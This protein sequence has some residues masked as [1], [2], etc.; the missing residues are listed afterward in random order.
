MSDKPSSV[1]ADGVFEPFNVEQMPFEQYSRGA[2]VGVRFQSFG[3]SGRV[4]V[5]VLGEGYR[6]SATM[7]YWEGQAAMTR[8]DRRRG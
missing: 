5:R 2:R 4:S 1:N 7:D 8:P 6:K 3:D